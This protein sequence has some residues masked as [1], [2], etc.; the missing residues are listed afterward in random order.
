MLEEHAGEQLDHILQPE[1]G[2]E[3]QERIVEQLQLLGRTGQAD[4]RH[5]AQAPEPHWA[6]GRGQ[7]DIVQQ[8][9]DE[10]YWTENKIISEK[11][12]NAIN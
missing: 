2:Q 5:V 9:V 6:P 4:G 1:D 7:G 8:I 10:G 3:L 12:R 11:L